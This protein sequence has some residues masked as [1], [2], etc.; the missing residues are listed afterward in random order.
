MILGSEQTAQLSTDFSKQKCTC[1]EKS[2]LKPLNNEENNTGAYTVASVSP[3]LL[4][5]SFYIFPS[6]LVYYNWN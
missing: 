2:P 5:S 1:R 4:F 3:P 6:S